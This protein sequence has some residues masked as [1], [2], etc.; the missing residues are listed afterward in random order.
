MKE[1]SAE[2]KL[3]QTVTLTVS[4]YRPKYLR[5]MRHY[6][7][8]RKSTLIAKCVVWCWCVAQLTRHTDKHFILT[9][10]YCFIPCNILD[11]EISAG[12]A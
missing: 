3:V 9:N 2:T 11:S 4:Y 10:T 7:H 1:L 8:V 6:W 5:H 12:E